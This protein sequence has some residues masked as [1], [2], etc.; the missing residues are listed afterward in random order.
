M[1]VLSS[2]MDYM[3]LHR[4]PPNLWIYTFIK[5]WDFIEVFFSVWELVLFFSL[6]FQNTPKRAGYI[7]SELF[8]N[9]I[10]KL[11][12]ARK[13]N[14]VTSKS[15]SNTGFFPWACFSQ[16]CL[17]VRTIYLDSLLTTPF[18]QSKAAEAT[19][20]LGWLPFLAKV[21]TLTVLSGWK[22]NEKFPLE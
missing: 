6:T 2:L 22:M 7:A 17:Q 9:K 12:Y 13:G 5:K 15:N 20:W 18:L 14:W 4:G 1:H 8:T 21:K 16:L 11:I 19:V 3:Y 10:V